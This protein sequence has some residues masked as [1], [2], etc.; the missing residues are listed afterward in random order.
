MPLAVLLG[1]LV[2]APLASA[3]SLEPRA[4]PLSREFREYQAELD[5]NQTTSLDGTRRHG[6]GMTPTPMDPSLME[7][8]PSLSMMTVDSL[9]A[10]YDLRTLGRLTPV[11]NQGALGTC[12]AFATYASLESSLLPSE[13]RD[14]SED[15][16]ALTSGFDSATPY[17]EGGNYYMSTAYL[18]RWGGPVD[19]ASDAYGDSFTPT[20]LTAKKH[21]QEV[22]Y[23]PGG[24]D[25][26]D[27]ANIKNAVM[28][29]GAVATSIHWADDAYL[30]GEFSYYYSGALDYDHGVAIVGWDDAF[31]AARFA[32][33]PP[34]DGAWLVRNSWGAAWGDGGYFWVSY[35]D[36]WC[37]TD[38]V[39]NAV[40]TRPA[41]TTNYNSVYYHDPLG[42]VGTVGYGDSNPAW[43]A[44]VFT[45]NKSQL[46]SA[47]GFFTHVPDTT[48]TVYTGGVNADG[49]PG[50]LTAKGS[51]TISTPG[52][53]TVTLS[54]SRWVTSGSKFTVAMKLAEPGSNYPIAY[55]AYIPDFSSAA[56]AAP[57]QSYLRYS[58]A[59]AWE[60]LTG[61]D[62]SANVCLK[63]YAKNDTKSPTTT[64]TA[65]SIRRY[66]TVTLKFRVN[67]PLPSCGKATVKVQI[68]KSGILVKTIS[69]GSRST[70][71]AASYKWKASLARGTYSWRA[72]AT[73]AAGHLASTMTSAKLVIY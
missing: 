15:N 40:Y 34:G 20:G 68:R 7:S 41:A 45:A 33:A 58:E 44:N 4:A 54:S 42:Q 35:H 47:V 21:V 56:S 67:D 28:T 22:L 36:T 39:F 59:Y 23:V 14:F 3:V 38:D 24:V 9:P 48:Y 5:I 2:A 49:S 16:M 30:Q 6:L 32:T 72:W 61:W 43:A 26:A 8:A 51:G 55:E 29:Y 50:A 10:T 1:L 25:A 53:H 17:G 70:N 69:I 57:G 27:T 52:F 11:R 66:S 13:A 73:D 46:I 64:A 19:E 37:G 62:S 63:A 71:V 65:A 12:W 18:L 60:D 31:S